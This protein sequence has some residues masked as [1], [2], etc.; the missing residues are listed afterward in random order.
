M[1]RIITIG[2]EFG[3]GGREVGKRIA[4]ELGI[5]YYD[6]EIITG[7]AQRTELAEEYVHQIIENKPIHYY[8]ITVGQSFNNTI[9]PLAQKTGAIY[10]EQSNVIREMAQT[11]DCVIVG[12]CA[13]FILRD[14]KPLRLYIYADMP[15]RIARCRKKGDHGEGMSDR[16]LAREIRRIDKDRAKYYSFFTGQKWGDRCNYDLCINT[17]SASIQDIVSAIIGM[18]EKI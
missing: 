10:A 9:N 4:E 17:S 2:R 12:R 16:R 5:A 18:L 11:S 13:D 15:S 6:N 8:P 3:S 7:I 1:S 14:L